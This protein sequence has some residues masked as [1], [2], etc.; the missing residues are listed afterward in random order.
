MA[1]PQIGKHLATFN[2]FREADYSLRITIADA[3]GVKDELGDSGAPLHL[4]AM[5]ALYAAIDAARGSPRPTV[6]DL[7]I[8][9]FQIGGRPEEQP[10]RIHLY[11]KPHDRP[12]GADV[13]NSDRADEVAVTIVFHDPAACEGFRRAL[14]NI[15]TWFRSEPVDVRRIV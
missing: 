8:G 11:R 3:R 1:D 14:D 9:Q 4:C 7:G 13:P 2:L 12:I 5:N 10:P 15:A 6:V